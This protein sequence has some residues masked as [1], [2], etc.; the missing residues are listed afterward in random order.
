MADLE[1]L[2]ELRNNSSFGSNSIS[3][4]LAKDLV[5]GG[6]AIPVRCKKCLFRK[7]DGYSYGCI[8]PHG[9]RGDLKE[10]DFCS[11]GKE[12]G[13]KHYYEK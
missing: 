9:L 8:N 12:K 7:W 3:G 4:N 1:K 5:T 10:T 13:G 11:N 6:A 2:I